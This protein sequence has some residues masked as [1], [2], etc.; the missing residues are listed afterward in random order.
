MQCGK[1]IPGADGR[2]SLPSPCRFIYI[3]TCRD[4]GKVTNTYQDKGYTLVIPSF[5]C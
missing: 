2:R 3:E 5:S 1:V 4:E